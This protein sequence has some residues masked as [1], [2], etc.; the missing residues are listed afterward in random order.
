MKKNSIVKLHKEDG[1]LT[2]NQA[3]IENMATDYFQALFTKDASVQP[4]PLIDCIEAVDAEMNHDLCK[5]F[6]DEE[7]SDALF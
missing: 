7:I 3:E 4:A 1:T 2:D 5:M 6:T